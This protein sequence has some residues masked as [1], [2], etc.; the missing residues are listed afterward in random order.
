MKTKK[1]KVVEL[2][3]GIIIVAIAITVIAITMLK[4]N[5]EGEKDMP[6]ILKQMV[7]ISTANGI[8][9]P[10]DENKWNINIY[11]NNDIYLEISRNTE[12]KSNETLKSVKIEN[13]QIIPTEKYTPKIYI[14][15]ID[16]AETFEY[17]QENEI[18]EEIN[19]AID[20]TQNIKERKIT[21]E[22]G[23][24]A[25]SVCI[26]KLGT[27]QGNDE[28]MTYD[29]TLLKRIGINKE[30]ITT[31]LKFDLIIETESSKKYKAQISLTLPQEDI[32]QT[33]IQKI[34]NAEL[35]NIVFKRAN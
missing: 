21:T 14:P 2:N 19:Y 8:N 6:Y 1:R 20:V 23:I 4:Y 30:D 17:V 5:V 9:T 28:K 24:L 31:N 15:D 18:S 13:I 25:L 7:I 33:G 35:N 11:Q 32:T 10:T 16:G 29:G 27:Y 26:P 12:Y 3:L 22:G 34:E